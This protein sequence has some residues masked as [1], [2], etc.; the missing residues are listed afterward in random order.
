MIFARHDD[1][2]LLVGHHSVLLVTATRRSL[3]NNAPFHKI[4]KV[5]LADA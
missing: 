4:V 3:I 5:G 2:C 1:V